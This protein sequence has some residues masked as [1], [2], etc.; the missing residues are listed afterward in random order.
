M[1]VPRLADNSSSAL[2]ATWTFSGPDCYFAAGAAHRGA[3]LD[4]A[5]ADPGGADVAVV[6]AYWRGGATVRLMSTADARVTWRG[7]HRAVASGV[8]GGVTGEEPG[9]VTLLL[10]EGEPVTLAAPAVVV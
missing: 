4:F 3:A 8:H 2:G 10:L 1:E 6:M 7:P 9:G 5:V